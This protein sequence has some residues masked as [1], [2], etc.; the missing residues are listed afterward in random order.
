MRWFECR[1]SE[2]YCGS[3]ASRLAAFRLLQQEALAELRVVLLPESAASRLVLVALRLA[4]AVLL[5]VLLQA[6][7]A[8]L[9]ALPALEESRGWLVSEL[10]SALARLRVLQP[11]L[12]ERAAWESAQQPLAASAT[13]LEWV[14]G[15]NVLLPARLQNARSG[16]VKT[17]LRNMRRRRGR[18]RIIRLLVN[19][20]CEKRLRMVC[21]RRL[22]R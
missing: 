19:D 12:V 3:A 9:L 7:A 2:R 14:I 5:A 20:D 21:R 22:G 10:V 4:S 8:L 16:A 11:G 15:A 17:L 1:S 6:W 18:G 13:S